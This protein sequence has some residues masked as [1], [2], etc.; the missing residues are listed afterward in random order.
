MTDETRDRDVR[1]AFARV[2]DAVDQARN[3]GASLEAAGFHVVG[4]DDRRAEA[5]KVAGQ[6]MRAAALEAR[7][8]I[9]GSLFDE[10]T[11]EA[12]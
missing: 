2:S 6:H 11:K 5:L 1:R 3:A 10:T 12:P 8:A 7:R 4:L 9:V